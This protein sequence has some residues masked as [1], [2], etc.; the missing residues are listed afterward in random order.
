[1]GWNGS[2]TFDRVHDWTDD[3]ANSIKVSATRMDEDVDDIVQNGLMN[4]L[5]K[6]AQIKPTVN[7]D[8]NGLKIINA[9]NGVDATDLATVGQATKAPVFLLSAGA[10]TLDATSL[11]KIIIAPNGT[12]VTTVLLPS[13]SLAPI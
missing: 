4:C 5:T 2:G 9:A 3:A 10:N 7:F 6:D 13:L 1:M 12:A 8:M 11:G